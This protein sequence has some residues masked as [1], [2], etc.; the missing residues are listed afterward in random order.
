MVSPFNTIWL[1]KLTTNHE[2]KNRR[3]KFKKLR[4]LGLNFEVVLLS[5]YDLS[6]QPI[7]SEIVE[8]V[9]EAGTK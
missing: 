8:V 1:L 6:N 9:E 4:N 2:A 3:N 5:V 7:L